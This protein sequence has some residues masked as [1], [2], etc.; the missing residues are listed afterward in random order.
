MGKTCDGKSDDM[1]SKILFPIILLVVAALFFSSL[2]R[3]DQTE[4][5]FHR[6][7][8][9]ANK[10]PWS[11]IGRIGNSTGGQCTGVVIGTHQILTAAHCLYNRGAHRFISAEYIHFLLGYVREQYRLHSVASRY[12][13][14]P[15]FDPIKVEAGLAARADDWAVLYVSDPFPSDTRPLRMA[16]V[17]PASGAPVKTAGYARERRY[18][19]TADDDCRIKTVSP[20]R[21]L[22]GHDCVIQ[23]GDSGG[24]LL[25]ADGD[26]GAVIEGINVSVTAPQNPLKLGFAVSAASITESLAALAPPGTHVAPTR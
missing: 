6:Q 22:I 12:I 18:M 8:V 21:K 14:P 13:V 16:T 5:I 17:V 9:D 23:S 10:Y 20:D 24:P 2:L 19:M 11:S 25:R 15:G 7:V 26:E 4:T 3:A 1:N